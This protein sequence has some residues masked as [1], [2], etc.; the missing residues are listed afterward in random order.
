MIRQVLVQNVDMFAWTAGDM[1]GVDPEVMSHRLSV[2]K[3]VR[4]ITQKKRKQREK[5][6]E[7][8]KKEVTKLMA[9]NFIKE[10]KYTTW[11]ANVEMVKKANDKWRMCTNYTDLN[12]VCSKD[13]YPLPSIDKLVD[14]AARHKILS[15]LDAYSGYNQIKMHSREQRENCLHDRRDKLL[16]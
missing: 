5:K 8:A 12:K 11:L 6:R 1:P 16:L 9:A 15:F 13:A 2:Y 4:P 10:A 14:G 7:A 3:D